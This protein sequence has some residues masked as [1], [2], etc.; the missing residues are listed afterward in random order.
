MSKI[1]KYI[2]PIAADYS[3]ACSVLFGMNTL[4]ILY[5]PSGCVHPIVE[6]DEIRDL[7]E[8]FLFSTK[9]NDIEVIM[10][11]E[12]KFLENAQMLV[13]NHPEIDFVSIVGTP[14][15]SIT[16]ISLKSLGKKL[17]FLTHK[18]VIAF[19]TSGFEN[20][21]VGINITLTKILEV[22]KSL[23]GNISSKTSKKQS[24]NIIGYSPLSLGHKS[25][26]D[27][28]VRTLRLNKLE[29]NFFPSFEIDLM[30]KYNF[31][32]TAVNIVVS[33]EGVSIA[34]DIYDNYGVPFIVNIPVGLHGMNFLILQLNKYLPLPIDKNIS[35]N[36]S[37]IGKNRCL[38][39]N[40]LIIGDPLLSIAIGQCIRYDFGMNTIKIVSLMNSKGKLNSMYSNNLFSDIIFTN[41]ENEIANYIGESHI[42]IADPIFE[43]SIN[44]EYQDCIFIP[45]PYPGLSGR[46]FSDDKY[47]YIGKSGFEYFYKYLNAVLTENLSISL[48]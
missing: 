36:C 11:T 13:L 30:L 1:L 23:N 39:K 32:E 42:I 22:K 45:I 41:D 7:N 47:E 19:E 28:F 27:E 34:R 12:E 26:L 43:T 6:I 8:V 9:L 37:S 20:Y 46:E 38:D 25:H 31:S 18:P 4:C 3:G 15:T 35:L 16:G 44:K 5:T 10:G 21:A 17:E 2:P 29:V 14:I 24:I 48:L 33:A 40:V